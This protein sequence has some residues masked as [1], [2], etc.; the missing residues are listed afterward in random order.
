MLD[1]LERIVH[2][3]RILLLVL[4]GSVF[5][6][7]AIVGVRQQASQVVKD[8]LRHSGAVLKLIEERFLA[9]LLHPL[10]HLVDGFFEHG[11]FDF[12]QP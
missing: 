2:F 5:I 9:F 3:F 6:L 10:G 11:P 1:D 7:G 4:V 12:A 8:V